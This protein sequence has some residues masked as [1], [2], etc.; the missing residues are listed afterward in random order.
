M[1]VATAVGYKAYDKGNSM[2]KFLIITLVMINVACSSN[3]ERDFVY[4]EPKF[5]EVYAAQLHHL[6]DELMMRMTDHFMMCDSVIIFPAKNADNN[7]VFQLLSADNGRLIT[8]FAYLGRSAE[9]LSNY[10]LMSVDTKRGL[11]F[12]MDNSN[13][14]I[15]I[16]LNRVLNNEKQYVVAS[17]R[18]KG[19]FPT[20]RAIHWRNGQLLQMGGYPTDRFFVTDE[21]CDTLLRYNVLPSL[22]ATIDQDEM[23]HKHYFVYNSHYAVRPDGRKIAN[24]TTNGMLLEILDVKDKGIS[25][26]EIKYFYEP[27]LENSNMGKSDCVFGASHICA[28]DDYIY[29]LYYDATIEELSNAKPKIG[30]F[31]WRGNEKRCYELNDMVA[32]FAISADD[33]RA[34]CLGYSSNGEEYLGYFNL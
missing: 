21:K 16:D 27:K 17:G 24:V 32:T 26:A 8:S 12:A 1:S 10:M 15:T 11:L 5:R 9:E 33:K 29:V 18:Y 19:D 3:T 20:S 2:C 22:T 4:S 13:R 23:L 31:D 14:H 34:Y 30:V 25:H 7:N 28:T 6:N